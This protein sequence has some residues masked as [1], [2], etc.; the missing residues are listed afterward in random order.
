MDE[1]RKRRQRS[2]HK[3]R[4]AV[5]LTGQLRLFMVGFPTLARNF[6]SVRQPRATR[7]TSSTWDRPMPLTHVA[8]L[9][10]IKYQGYEIGQ[11]IR[12]GCDGT[13]AHNVTALKLQPCTCRS[14]LW[15]TPLRW[16]RTGRGP[17]AR[18]A[19]SGGARASTSMAWRVAASR[20]AGCNLEWCRRCKHASAC[21]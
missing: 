8:D 13:A 3:S 17:A 4:L 5:C 20:R 6:C 15:L 10:C 1:L 21:G 9:F 12:L 7:L 11:C 2:R 16:A 18:A 14:L 19:T